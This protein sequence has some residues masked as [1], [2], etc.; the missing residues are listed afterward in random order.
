[1]GLE[2]SR[3]PA[4]LNITTTPSRMDIRTRKARLEFSTERAK[5]EVHT[6]LP[7]VV[8]DQYECFKSMGL[9]GPVDLTRQEGQYAMRQA[10]TYTEKVSADGDAIAAIENPED[11]IPAIV[12]RDA[13]PEKEFVI[14]CIPKARPQITVTGGVKVNVTGDMPGAS[15]GVQATYTPPDIRISFTPARVRISM[16]QYPSISMRYV[17][18]RFDRYV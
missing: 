14:D 15:N 3:I 7:R 10:V 6:E 1:M 16:A 8:I 2:I 13:F 17:P 9:M 5:V 4:K 11:P 12:E 18:N